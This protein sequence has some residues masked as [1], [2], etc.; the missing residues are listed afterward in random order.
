MVKDLTAATLTKMAQELGTEPLLIVQINWSSGTEYYADKEIAVGA[1]TATGTI[2]S[3]SEISSSGKQD[4]TGEISSINIVLDDTDGTLKTKV[5]EV[6]IEGT[7]GTVYQHFVGNAQ[8][9]LTPLLTGKIAGDILWS[10]GERTLTFDLETAIEDGEVGCAP[11]AGAFPD[12]QPE[13][14]DKPW[15]LAFGTVLN[16]PAVRVKFRP[17]GTLANGIN[18]NFTSFTVTGGADFPQAPTVIQIR[19]AGILYTGTMVGELFT[20]TSKNDAHNINVQITNRLFTDPDKNESA[21][22]WIED[23]SIN[24]SLQYCYVDHPT[25][26]TMIN[27]CERQEGQKCF[28]QKSWQSDDGLQQSPQG[29]TEYLLDSTN[30]ILETSSV[31]RGSWGAP[32]IWLYITHIPAG[33]FNE[34]FSLTQA[35][36]IV[37]GDRWSIN[38]DIDVF[39][40]VA[41]NDTYVVNCI[42]GIELLRV[43]AYRQFDRKRLLMAVPSTYYTINLSDTLGDENPFTIEFPIALRDRPDE[44]WED[45]IFVSFRSSQGANITN[46]IKFLVETFSTMAIDTTSFDA[47]RPKVANFPANFAIFDQPNILSLIESIAFQARCVLFIK[48]G[49]VTIIYLSEVPTAVDTLTENN[50][51]LKTIDLSFTTTEDIVTK[52]DATW[53]SDYSGRDENS[54]TFVYRNNI[55]L[56]GLRTQEINF[57]I[58]NIESLVQL[59]AAFWGFRFSNSWRVITSGTFLKNLEFETLDAVDYNIPAISSNTLLGVLEEVGHDTGTDLISLKSTLASKAGGGGEPTQDDDYFEGDPSFQIPGSSLPADP[60]ADIGEGGELPTAGN[61]AE[62]DDAEDAEGGES[63]GQISLQ[64]TFTLHPVTVERGISYILTVQAL[65]SAGQI[66]N[67]QTGQ[68]TITLSLSS[69][70]PADGLNTS[71]VLLT[72]GQH[73]FTGVQ[74]TGGAG[75]DPTTIQVTSSLSGWATGIFNFTVI[76]VQLTTLSWDTVPAAVVRNA[77]FTIAISGGAALGILDVQLVGSDTN[78]KL[79]DASGEVTQITLDGSGNFTAS[80]WFI[81]GGTDS[82]TGNFV[83]HDPGLIFEDEISSQFTI[84]GISKQLISQL[85]PITQTLNAKLQFIE[86]TAPVNITPG[87]LFALTLTL[88]NSDGSTD[89]TFNGQFRLESTDLN[90]TLLSWGDVGP[91]AESFTGFILAAAT[92]GVWTYSAVDLNT[93]TAVSPIDFDALEFQGVA[94]GQATVPL[95]GALAFLIT[96]PPETLRSTDFTMSITAVIGINVDTGFSEDVTLA[97][98]IGDVGDSLTITTILAASFVDGVAT[99]T[100]QQITGGAGADVTEISA[101]SA[102]RNGTATFTVAPAITIIGSNTGSV[103]RTYF[104]IDSFTDPGFIAEPS[105][106]NEFTQTQIDAQANFDSDTVLSDD[107]IIF[108]PA[109]N[110]IFAIGIASRSVT[111]IETYI[112][113]QALVEGGFSGFAP[114]GMTGLLS[115]YIRG[116][117]T[118]QMLEAPPPFFEFVFTP[119]A[120]QY[121]LNIKIVKRN[122]PDPVTFTSGLALKNMIPDQVVTGAELLQLHKNVSTNPNPGVLIDIRLDESIFEGMTET[123]IRI[124]VYMT[125]PNVPYV[126]PF[127]LL[128]PQ[129]VAETIGFLPTAIILHKA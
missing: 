62:G 84:A 101:T 100:A 54:N 83:L 61:D 2:L 87:S 92:N 72:G 50:T 32:F 119:R 94:V 46:I 36:R 95:A 99:L 55:S 65:N 128:I 123:D 42:P 85:I 43:S 33:L 93:L 124:W 27:F 47:V 117:L 73:T 5:N 11:G 25:A 113:T 53:K 15:P 115:V 19:I 77:P 1:I 90:N 106:S 104:G 24:L 80:D 16:V 52:I 69:G 37:S 74:I 57:F 103:P 40:E 59:S 111:D 112:S 45:D 35:A 30:I 120:E 39:L 89:T 9:D 121:A 49:V 70:D 66:V 96:L 31:P 21:I 7:S 75:T 56:F 12:L 60:G 41:F 127:N 58:Y 102:S 23:G 116:T 48:N 20:F 28:F 109:G 118:F 114:A 51:Q 10:E 129:Q 105:N 122:A 4:S 14:I 97:I 98:S 6:I 81:S 17:K 110:R 86:I 82:D 125:G 88:K 44:E 38:A 71:P 91:E 3:A 26:G 108:G 13:A 107:F 78:D 18:Q 29:G 64:L 79:F 67:V 63:G 8:A 34:A 126:G 22:L 76:A 68:P